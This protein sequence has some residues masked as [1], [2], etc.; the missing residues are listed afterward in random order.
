MSKV[1]KIILTVAMV[2]IFFLLSAFIGELRG[3]GGR[4]GVWGIIFM[5]ALVGGLRALWKKPKNNQK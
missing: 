5:L 1:S 4:T 2:L 3:H